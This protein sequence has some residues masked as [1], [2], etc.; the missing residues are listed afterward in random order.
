VLTIRADMFVADRIP[1]TTSDGK[2]LLQPDL[3][4]WVGTSTTLN[5]ATVSSC[6]IDYARHVTYGELSKVGAAIATI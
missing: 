4:I 6:A 3:L 1:K 5:E 2:R